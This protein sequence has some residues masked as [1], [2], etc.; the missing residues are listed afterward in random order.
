MIVRWIPFER[1]GELQCSVDNSAL[2]S[3]YSRKR[4]KWMREKSV[5]RGLDPSRCNL[6]ATVYMDD[7]PFCTVHAGRRLIEL[8]CGPEPRRPGLA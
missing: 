6:V 8:Q 7:Q 5:R 4:S 2:A 1:K 3:D